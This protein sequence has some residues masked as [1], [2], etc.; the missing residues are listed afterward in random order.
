MERSKGK[1]KWRKRRKAKRKVFRAPGMSRNRDL[2]GSLGQ[3]VAL[4]AH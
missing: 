3:K 2:V 1:G 4:A